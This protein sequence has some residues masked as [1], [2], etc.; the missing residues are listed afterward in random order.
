MCI[1]T[2]NTG[3]DLIQLKLWPK[4]TF[5]VTCV[6]CYTYVTIINQ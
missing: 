1:F 2:G 5:R 6:K 3:T 4:Y